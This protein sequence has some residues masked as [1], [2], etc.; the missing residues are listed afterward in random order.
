MGAE[1][2][3]GSIKESELNAIINTDKALG[4]FTNNI[5]DAIDILFK[6]NSYI[7]ESTDDPKSEIGQ[8]EYFCSMHYAYSGTSGR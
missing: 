6:L 2:S 1:I 7:L 8:F 3:F 5:I 4:G